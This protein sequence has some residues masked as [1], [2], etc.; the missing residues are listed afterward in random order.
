[1]KMFFCTTDSWSMKIKRRTTTGTGRMRHLKKL[2]RRFK[3]GFQEGG[4]AKSQ[5]RRGGSAAPVSAQ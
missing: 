4:Q 1:M 2:Y 5:K 3:N